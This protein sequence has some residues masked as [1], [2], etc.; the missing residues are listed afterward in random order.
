MKSFSQFISEQSASQQAAR[1]G[2]DGNGHGDWYNKEGEFVAKTVGGK[3]KFYNKRQR[4]PG[5]DP[6]QTERERNQPH[7]TTDPGEAQVQ[8][9]GQAAAQDGAVEEPLPVQSPDLAAGP[10]PVPK[11]KGTLTI[12]FGRFNPPHAGHLKLMDLAAQSAEE[13]EEGG[14]YMIVPSRTNDHK[15]NPLDPDSKVQMMRKLFPQHSERI[16]NDPQNR[17]IFDIL[18]K[19]HNDGY[20][21]VRIIG[22]EDRVKQFDK[23]SQNYNGALYQFDNLETISSGERD[24]DS[25]GTEGYS[26]SKMRLAAAE[27]DFATFYQQLQ[28]EVDAVDEFDEPIVEVDPK[29]GDKL[30]DKEGKP[31]IA[32]ELVPIISKKDA[33][34][35]FKQ[36]R[37][38]MRADEIKEFWNIWEIAPKDDAETLRDIYIEGNI[39]KLDQLVEDVNTGLRGKIIR[40][41]TSY[42][43]CVTEDNIM[44]KSWVKDLMEIVKPAAQTGKYGVPSKQREVGT[45]ELRKYAQSMVPGQG[46]INNLD[47]KEFIN[48]YRKK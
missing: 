28:Q 5:Q 34:E 29:T 16:I 33:K 21:N 32:K 27:D 11:T 23:L 4:T 24:E 14:D 41:G 36:V 8:P 7:S 38:A 37:S 35:Y 12:G 1:M 48:K 43:I 39:F 30:V 13:G 25:E 22:G 15:K 44:F 20:A 19:A 45:P 2:L 31:L 40:R 46:V 47:I 3:L 42:L 10:P 9:Q 17:T 18:K 6:P 26:A